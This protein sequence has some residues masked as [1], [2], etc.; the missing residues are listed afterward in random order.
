MSKISDL[1]LKGNCSIFACLVLALFSLMSLVVKIGLYTIVYNTMQYNH[2]LL[3]TGTVKK[4][5]AGPTY[6]AEAPGKRD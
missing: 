6:T 4:Q 5:E 1:Q 3:A 2:H